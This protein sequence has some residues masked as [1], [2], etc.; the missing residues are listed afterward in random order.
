MQFKLPNILTI[1]RIAAIPVVVLLLLL[2][3]PLGNWLAF[4]IYAT[5]CITDF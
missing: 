5:A 1:S 2:P 4:A 3:Q